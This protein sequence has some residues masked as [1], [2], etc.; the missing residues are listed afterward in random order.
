[1]KR[2]LIFEGIHGSEVT[3]QI[4]LD[5][6]EFPQVSSIILNPLRRVFILMQEFIDFCRV[7]IFILN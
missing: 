2:V 6:R 3:W 4:A 1:M 7:V 5:C